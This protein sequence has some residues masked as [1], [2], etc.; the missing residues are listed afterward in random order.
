[1]KKEERIYNLLIVDDHKVVRDGI[2][3]LIEEEGYYKVIAKVGNGKEA[4]TKIDEADIVILDLDMPEMGGLEFLRKVRELNTDLKIIVLT[5][6]EQEE[7]IR[8][9]VESGANGYVLKSSGAERLLEALESVKEGGFYFCSDATD[10]IMKK[11]TGFDN[12]ETIKVDDIT[13]R[14]HE[15]LKLICDELTNVEIAEK[16]FISVRTVDT[17]RSNLLQKTGAKNT[18]GLVKFAITTG[19]ISAGMGK[20]T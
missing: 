15:V 6:I 16:L 12:K 7:M 9:V 8:T 5:M 19:I 13:P 20:N 4:L 3:A 18:A 1:M 17:H 11:L 10:I 14:E 2:A